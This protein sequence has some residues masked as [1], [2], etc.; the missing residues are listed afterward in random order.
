MKIK[1]ILIVLL[2][3][4]SYGLK[5]QVKDISFTLSP[6]G[7]YTWWDNKAGLED[8]FLIGGKLGFGFGEYLE[9]RALY[10]Q[11][12][13]MKTNFDNFGFSGITTGLLSSNNVDLTRWGGEFK[14][15]LGTKKLMPYL[16]LGAGIQ[17]IETDYT[18]KVKQI[19]ASAGLGIK[20]T[21]DDR[22][23]LG[24]EGKNTT[25]NFNAGQ[26]LLTDADKAILGLTN[27]NFE[28]KRLSNWSA[29]ASLQFYLGGRRPGTLTDLDRA[30]LNRFKGGFKGL[31]LVLEPGGNYIDFDKNS[32]LR[33]TYMLG[34]YVGLDFNE[35]V[36]LR[37][38]YFQ[39]ARNDELSTDF[40]DLNM[41]GLE[42]RARLNDGNGVTPYLT[43][44]G[45]YLNPYTGYVGQ[46]GTAVKGS[47]FATGGLGLNIPLGKN[48]FITGGVK[49]MATLG[50]DVLNL[51]SPDDVQ[52]H[53]VYNAGLQF[54]LGKKSEQPHAVYEQEL[55]T[56]LDEKQAANDARIQKLK[57]G[58][59]EQ[60][61]Q[62]ES[63]LKTAYESNDVDKAVAVLEEKQKVQKS[64]DQVKQVET[65]ATIE[66]KSVVK[67]TTVSPVMPAVETPQKLTQTATVEGPQK[68]MMQMTPAEF[69]ILISRILNDVQEPS[70]QIAIPE[71]DAEINYLN[72]RIAKLENLLVAMNA[73]TTD[74]TMIKQIQQL[75]TVSEQKASADQQDANNELILKELKKLNEKVDANTRLIEEQKSDI[76][77]EI[78]SVEVKAQETEV[79]E[80][81]ENIQVNDT[82]E[83]PTS[84]KFLTYRNTSVFLGFNYGGASTGNF[85]VRPFFD[86]KKTPLLFMPEVYIGY[87]EDTS[88]GISGNVIYPFSIKS[89]D[90]LPY[91]GA[92]LGYG[93]IAGDGKL[94]YNIILGA[95]LPFINK[96]LYIDYTMRNGF[97]YNQLGIGYHLPF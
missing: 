74:S 33:D 45:G 41:Y 96:N 30:Y 17:S 38:F 93:N 84:N 29:L 47:E 25:F 94:N 26:A 56:Q 8:N 90:V 54:S 75:K 48:V 50:K 76:R 71:K 12:L 51:D 92:G 66:P 31:Q 2:L 81:V 77:K 89:E 53:L 97:D 80:K 7:E 59:E 73:N 67:D 11:S 85:A 68:E 10:M 69:E 64:L 52:A 6:A 4:L 9:L 42:F 78:E 43:L 18:A 88:Y 65:V 16:T 60:I 27:A 1:Q 39:A 49:A 83:A 46:N 61:A 79:P 20:F 36:G 55:Q 15:N 37:A 91:V 63:D 19:Y 14:A 13:D 86:I 82:L 3:I 95:N 44:G 40:D 32:L 57:S 87:G 23:V 21:I 22:I 62:L 58:Y 24:I 34:G 28:S 70:K 72:D 35:F 5:A